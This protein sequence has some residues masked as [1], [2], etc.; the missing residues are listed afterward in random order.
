MITRSIAWSRSVG[1]SLQAIALSKGMAR[2]YLATILLCWVGA[3]A[4]RAEGAKDPLLVEAWNEFRAGRN[5]EAAARFTAVVDRHPGKS[6]VRLQ[7]L[8]GYALAMGYSLP[9]PKVQEALAALKTVVDADPQGEIAPWAI[10]EMGNLVI[11]RSRASNPVAAAH[12]QR[13]LTEFPGS[14]AA[15]EA[16]LKFAGAKIAEGNRES[17]LQGINAL[18][19]HLA[20]RPNNP[21]AVVMHLRLD[22]AYCV[23]LQ[24]YANSLRHAEAVCRLRLRDPFRWSRQ[25]W[26]TAELHRRFS[27]DRERAAHFYRMILAEAPRSEHAWPARQRLAEWGMLDP[28]GATDGRKPHE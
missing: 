20:Q 15:D 17:V 14:P 26:H 10:L 1:R 7:A 16:A 2:R 21:A 27:G 25:L 11:D 8:Y 28:A 23:I 4:A 13:V 19:A 24:D 5:N 22:Y 6:P 9:S 12:F 18:E 3:M